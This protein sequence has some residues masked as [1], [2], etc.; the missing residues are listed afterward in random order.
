MHPGRPEVG[1]NRYAYA[2]GNPTNFTDRTGLYL[3]CFDETNEHGLQVCIWI[4]D[5]VFEV[6]AGVPPIG[7]PAE[8]VYRFPGWRFGVNPILAQPGTAPDTCE[9]L[10]TC[11]SN[12]VGSGAGGGSGGGG[13]GG[14]T[15]S[16]TPRPAPVPS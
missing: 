1:T 8:Y 6:S 9:E 13:G 15:P 16:P 3:N 2:L 5:M 11:D 4:D 7:I 10:G 14:A 12:T